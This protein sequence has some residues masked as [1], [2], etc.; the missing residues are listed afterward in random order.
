MSTENDYIP[1]RLAF[2][3][4][5]APYQRQH[6]AVGRFCIIGPNV[7][8]GNGTV[9][10]NNVTISG[11]VKIGENCLIKSN[12]VI[13]EKGFSWGFTKDLEP[14]AIVHTGGVV[15]GNNVE[16]GAL[17]T[18]AGGTLEPTVLGDYVKLDDHIHI[19]HNCKVGRKTIITAGVTLSGGVVAGEKCW[20]GLHSTYKNKVVL[21]DRTLVGSGANVINDTDYGDIVVGNPAKVIRKRD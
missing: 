7:S 15:I 12:T 5:R 10:R 19:A 21:A 9:I 16:I 18:V 11:K 17:C 3:R 6:P 2:A 1:E 8:I 4:E 20:L 13:G 14:V